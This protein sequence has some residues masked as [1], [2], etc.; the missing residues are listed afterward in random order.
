MQMEDSFIKQAKTKNATVIAEVTLA[1][2]L[3]TTF[4]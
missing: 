4:S 1:F 2:C 3:S